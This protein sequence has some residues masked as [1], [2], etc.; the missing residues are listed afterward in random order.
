MQ[1]KRKDVLKAKIQN[2]LTVKANNQLF[3][4]YNCKCGLR[5]SHLQF[6]PEEDLT[7]R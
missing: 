3:F 4:N 6:S 5:F 7:L 1:Q 2:P